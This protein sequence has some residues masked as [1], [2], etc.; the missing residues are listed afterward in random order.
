VAFA[1]ISLADRVYH[2]T[3]YEDGKDLGTAHGPTASLDVE[4]DKH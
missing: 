1:A 4:F 3:G 2:I